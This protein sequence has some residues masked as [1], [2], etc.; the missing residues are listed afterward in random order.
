MH[1][2]HAQEGQD[3]PNEYHG[4]SAALGSL[5]PP[6]HTLTAIATRP[7][8]RLGNGRGQ[9]ADADS[10]YSADLQRTI[11]RITPVTGVTL[12]PSYRGYVTTLRP[13]T[14]Y[15]RLN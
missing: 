15:T 14:L 7:R 2:V 8:T 1:S 12:R 4:F 3:A 9:Q 10:N 5:P 6:P 13:L 11:V